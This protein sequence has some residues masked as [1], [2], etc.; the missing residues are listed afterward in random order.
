M[1]N[2]ILVIDDDQELNSLLKNYLEKSGLSVLSATDPEEGLKLFRKKK[3]QAVILD[4]ML[5][6]KDGF[7]VCREIRKES[8]V[9]VIMLTA[10]GEVTDRVVG[11]E[12]GADD[13]LPKPFD[14]RELLARIRTVL[15]RSTA[16]ATAAAQGI[17]SSGEL[18][19]SLA[20]RQA[21]IKS[22]KLSLTTTEFDILGL[23]LKNPGTVM[24][25]ER[26]LNSIRTDSVEVFDR[27]VDLAISRLR[28]KLGDSGKDP[29]YIKTI[30][31]S[32]YLFS[33]KVSR[34]DS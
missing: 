26:I 16:K 25:R 24:D 33:G 21:W 30:W 20:E 17:L 32:G 5:P 8:L 18:K 31:G 15:R 29:K 7:E 27:S 12:I 10:R 28:A 9:P 1:A 6:G 19:L 34:R 23:F 2:N 14:P 13:Y 4:V 3:P 22:K 11:L